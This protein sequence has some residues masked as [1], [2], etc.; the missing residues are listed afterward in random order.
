MDSKHVSYI[1][2][3]FP[4]KFF[5]YFNCSED[6]VYGMSLKWLS[7]VL[8]NTKSNMDMSMKFA[9]NKCT[10]EFDDNK[11]TKIYELNLI[12]LSYESLNIPCDY[13]TN[14]FRL[15]SREIY[16]IFK[17]VS[18]VETFVKIVY[19]KNNICFST[20]GELGKLKINKNYISDNNPIN[21]K[22]SI[23]H[24][25]TISKLYSLNEY[26]DINIIND[27]PMRC[28]YNMDDYNIEFYIAPKIEED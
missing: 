9:E 26:I 11:N 16:E 23:T 7:K 2:C 13:D 3:I 18:T 27:T 20:D 5:E 1:K 28:R 21:A 6:K 22:F 12:E 10:I 14:L 15:N 25:L 4:P 8:S 17:E 19:N 24:L